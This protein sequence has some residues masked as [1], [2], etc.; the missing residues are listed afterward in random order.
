MIENASD[1]N[2]LFREIC[3]HDLRINNMLRF[4]FDLKTFQLHL[5]LTMKCFSLKI[6][7]S[8]FQRKKFS[9]LFEAEFNNRF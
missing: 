4:L 2:K 8:M 5:L 9:L 6:S 7:T 1:F 3:V